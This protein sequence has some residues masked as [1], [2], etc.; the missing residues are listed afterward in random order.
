MG[1]FNAMSSGTALLVTREVQD[2]VPYGDNKV[3]RIA[4]HRIASHRI[5]SYRIASQ[6]IVSYRIVPYRKFNWGKSKSTLLFRQCIIWRQERRKGKR[7][8]IYSLK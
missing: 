8:W 5:V 3:Y 2:K 1:V 7:S 6:R 4:S